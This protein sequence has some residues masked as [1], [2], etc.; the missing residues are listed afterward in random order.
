MS[1]LKRMG[2]SPLIL[3]AL[4]S[5]AM[6]GV[7][8]T[9]SVTLGGTTRSPFD[10]A[11]LSTAEGEHFVVRTPTTQAATLEL[12]TEIQ[13][14]KALGPVARKTLGIEVARPVAVTKSAEG[15]PVAVFEY[16]HGSP[17]DLDRTRVDSP[18][19]ASIGSTIGKIHQIDPNSVAD[20]GLPS[21]S[22]EDVLASRIAEFDR[23][24]ETGKVPAKLLQRW[25]AALD[26]VSLV[27]FHPVVVHG[28]IDGDSLLEEGGKVSGLLNWSK[29]RVS[30][31]AEDLVWVAGAAYPDVVDAIFTAYRAENA[32]FDLGLAQRAALYSEMDIARWLLHGITKN[33][34]ET[35][36]DGEAM[37]SALEENLAAG[38]LPELKPGGFASVAAA[39]AVADVS[40]ISVEAQS[41]TPPETFAG[42][43][44]RTEALEIIEVTETLEVSEVVETLEASDET[45]GEAIDAAQEAPIVDDKTRPIELPEKKDDELF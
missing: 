40:V 12:A 31:P 15:K 30:D 44:T 18:L 41:A 10:S 25:E 34:P 32:N 24:A 37:L 42:E 3:A 2:K 29:L 35:I 22:I 8:F 6:P 23:F 17:I 5:D 27:R 20:A 21:F 38:S 9:N 11:L 1:N 13:A 45:D 36:A 7:S 16:V 14:L 26:D 4:A 39:A 19:L 43:T 28:A 33:D